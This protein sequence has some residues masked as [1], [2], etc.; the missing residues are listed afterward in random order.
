MVPL[1]Q[2]STWTHI[3]PAMRKDGKLKNVSGDL[4]FPQS[5]KPTDP[6]GFSLRKAAT[7]IPQWNAGL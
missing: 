4:L 3:I 5:G 1:A 2:S 6:T 7:E